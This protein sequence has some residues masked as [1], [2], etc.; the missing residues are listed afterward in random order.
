MLLPEA[1]NVTADDIQAIMEAQKAYD[2]LSAADK[3]A[4]PTELA[5][6]MLAVYSAS[7]PVIL[8]DVADRVRHC[9][10]N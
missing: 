9:R 3:K 1:K 2:S 8:K 6:K 4:V 5:Q 10:T 7:M